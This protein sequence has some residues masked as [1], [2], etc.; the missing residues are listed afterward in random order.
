MYSTHKPLL[1]FLHKCHHCKRRLHKNME[2]IAR[3]WFMGDGCTYDW[4]CSKTCAITDLT[5]ERWEQKCIDELNQEI[6]EAAL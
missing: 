3:E 2:I 4:Y 1:P 5:N 6:N